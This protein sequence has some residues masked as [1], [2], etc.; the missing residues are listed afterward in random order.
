MK[1]LFRIMVF[2]CLVFVG[3]VVVFSLYNFDLIGD[4]RLGVERETQAQNEGRPY[5]LYF[6]SEDCLLSKEGLGL[7]E[8][9]EEGQAD[10]RL[11]MDFIYVNVEDRG[12]DRY[13]WLKN[14]EVTPTLLLYDQKAILKGRFTGL[15]DMDRLAGALARLSSGQVD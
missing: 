14:I 10:D 11:E 4:S 9:L 8:G 13:A 5:L 7:I 12:E 1:Q 6:Y 3:V 2:L 15:M